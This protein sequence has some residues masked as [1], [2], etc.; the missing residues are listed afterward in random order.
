MAIIPLFLQRFGRGTLSFDDTRPSKS[1]LDEKSTLFTNPTST[2]TSTSKPKT[3]PSSRHSLDPNFSARR[4]ANKSTYHRESPPPPPP[5]SFSSASS[6][7]SDG[8]S[9]LAIGSQ[10]MR[11]LPVKTKR[12]RL[13]GSPKFF[14]KVTWVDT[15]S[16]LATLVPMNQI[17]IPQPVY[18]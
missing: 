10:S 9:D 13:L 17:N 2:S 3:T 11:E 14:A 6:S 15:L 1:A 4:S 5:L 16:Q 18:E 12:G 8:S 7:S